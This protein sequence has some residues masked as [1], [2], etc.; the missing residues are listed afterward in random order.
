MGKGDVAASPSEG[1]HFIVKLALVSVH[2][3]AR[4]HPKSI[5]RESE[6]VSKKYGLRGE[7]KSFPLLVGDVMASN[8]RPDKAK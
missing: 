3:S 5:T 8:E 1:L 2:C 6:L 4:R 7:V